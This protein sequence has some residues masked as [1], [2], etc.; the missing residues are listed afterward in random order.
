M[1]PISFKVEMIQKSNTDSKCKKLELT[2]LIQI[3][4]IVV[5]L[6]ERKF[7]G[8]LGNYFGISVYD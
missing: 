2:I 1:M 4:E 5:Q 8:S 3:P 7:P 6:S